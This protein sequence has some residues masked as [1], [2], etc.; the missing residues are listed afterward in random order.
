M[1]KLFD[2]TVSRRSKLRFCAGLFALAF[3][4]SVLTFDG[5]AFAQPGGRGGRSAPGGQPGARGG[6]R[7]GFQQNR[8]GAT[9]GGDR[10]GGAP[11]RGAGNAAP[12]DNS[13]DRQGGDAQGNSAPDQNDGQ[14]G[15]RPTPAAPLS[16]ALMSARPGEPTTLNQQE[17]TTADGVRLVADFY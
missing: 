7:P 16:S 8:G 4:T 15:G 13:N 3:A 6:A 5:V 10:Q 17:F 12:G 2:K 1:L 11:N 14:N 9:A